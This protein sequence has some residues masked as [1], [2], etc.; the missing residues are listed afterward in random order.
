MF[1]KYLLKNNI[2]NKLYVLGFCV[3]ILSY[4]LWKQTEEMLNFSEENEGAIY[5]IGIAFSFCCYTSA[6]MFTK[7]NKWRYF[8]MI[9]FSI[10]LSRFFKEIYLLYYP[11]EVETYD[12]FDYFNF[13]VTVWI[14]F[15]YYVK[16]RHKEFKKSSE[17]QQ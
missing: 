2:A 4:S 12:F 7:W 10:C 14:V 5:F 11:E 13:L 17:Q 3:A 8:P 6:Y 9:A 16:Q 1:L 15:N